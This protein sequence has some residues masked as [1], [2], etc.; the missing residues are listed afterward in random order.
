METLKPI[1]KVYRDLIVFGLISLFPFFGLSQNEPVAALNQPPKSFAV[2]VAHFNPTT[3][4][5][6]GGVAGSAFFVTPSKALTA[7]HVLNK[8]SFEKLS[9]TEIVK[10]W[11]VREHQHP[12]AIQ[13]PTLIEHA[14][15]DITA[16]DFGALEMVKQ[17]EVY[18]VSPENVHM[19]PPLATALESDGFVASTKGPTLNFDGID[20]SI[21]SVPY[22]SRLHK[23][24][25]LVR[26]AA[27]TLHAADVKLTDVPCLQV[28]YEPVVGLSGGPITAQGKL[29]AINSFADPSKASTWGVQL[30]SSTIDSLFKR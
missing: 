9:P 12:I 16:I 15:K 13:A 24:G 21:S 4:E 8:K 22:L 17:S 3:G 10:I 7:F 1:N 6:K 28:T 19:G 26:S 29:V 18:E 27:I 20:L 30:T 11:L 23:N 5:A 2:F 25:K 14:P